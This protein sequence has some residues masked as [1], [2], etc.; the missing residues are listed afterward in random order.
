LNKK[1]TQKNEKKIFFSI[2]IFTK[3]I[4]NLIFSYDFESFEANL[5]LIHAW[6]GFK[7]TIHN[8]RV[9]QRWRNLFVHKNR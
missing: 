3:F 5:L 9:Q 1:F 4:K 8:D 6:G 7:Y 2:L